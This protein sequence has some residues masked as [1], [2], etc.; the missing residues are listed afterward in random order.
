MLRV[1]SDCTLEC[2][3]SVTSSAGDGNSRKLAQVTAQLQDVW[4][5]F[6]LK[7]LE[8][9]ETK[10]ENLKNVVQLQKVAKQNKSLTKDI[11]NMKVSLEHREHHANVELG[12]GEVR[13]HTLTK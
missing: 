12:R 9:M 3:Q 4:H 5:K 1:V 6:Q 7:E 8:L 11:E 13:S 2:G 10:K